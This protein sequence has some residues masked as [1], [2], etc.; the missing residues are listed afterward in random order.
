MSQPPLS[1]SVGN[2]HN[3]ANPFGRSELSIAPDGGAH[4]DHYARGDFHR[5]WTGNVQAAALDRLWSALERAGFPSSTQPSFVLPDS[6]IRTLTAETEGKRATLQIAWRAVTA[7][8][9]YDEAF[10]ILDAIIRQLRQ[11]TV[12]STSADPQVLVTQVQQTV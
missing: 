8:P 3:P 1:Y 6:T 12:Q 5:A 7:L 2:E 4:L 11:D 10:A 9:G